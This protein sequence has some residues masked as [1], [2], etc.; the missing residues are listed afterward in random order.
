[1]KKNNI[2]ELQNGNGFF[3]FQIEKNELEILRETVNQHFSKII[4]S[5]YPDLK[6]KTRINDYHKISKKVEHNKIWPMKSRVLSK[7]KYNIFLESKLAKKLAE[8]FGK[9]SISDENNMGHGELVWRLVR[10][11]E[12]S[13]VGPIHCDKWFWDLNPNHKV[14]DSCERIKCWI[15]LWCDNKNGL[16]IYPGSQLKN[17]HYKSEKRH[18]YVKPIFDESNVE[19]F[20][21]KQNCTPG[22]VIVF[23]DKLLHGGVV[24]EGTETRVSMEFTMFVDKN[25]IS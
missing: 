3:T 14:P 5:T 9:F 25:N 10:P 18:G 13:D 4:N 23:N 8:I 17:F 20:M 19:T 6:L 16:Q 21:Q 22:T 12:K 2:L 1:M 15:S 7:E 11:N 24:N